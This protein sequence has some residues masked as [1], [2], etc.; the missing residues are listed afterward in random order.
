MR[1]NNISQEKCEE[2]VI[3]LAVK[4]DQ[5]DEEEVL[6]II[7]SIYKR[8]PRD[9]SVNFSGSSALPQ[10]LGNPT[11]M[12]IKNLFTPGDIINLV[13]HRWV[14]ND[15]TKERPY[16]KGFF[17]K[18]EDLI[19]Q[20]EE[21]GGDINNDVFASKKGEPQC[22]MTIAINP[23]KSATRSIENVKAFRHLLIEFD[24]KE[25]SE[26]WDILKNSNLPISTVTYSGG[27]S[28]HACV[29]IDAPNLEEFVFRREIV[30][31]RLE[32]YSPDTATKD[33]TRLTRLAGA[34]RKDVCQDLIAVNI[35]PDSWEEFEA[36]LV[37]KGIIDRPFSWAKAIEFDIE[38]T[39]LVLLGDK[40]VE[41]SGSWLISAQTGVGKSVLAVQAAASFALGLD[42]LGLVPSKP[43]RSLMFQAENGESDVS[44]VMKSIY[45]RLCRG[46]INTLQ[47]LESNCIIRRVGGYYEEQFM[48]VLTKHIERYKPDLIWL[49][50]LTAFIINDITDKATINKFF[51]IDLDPIIHKYR[52]GLV[53]VHHTNKPPRGNELSKWGIDDYIYY[54][55]GA[56][57]MFNYFRAT[58]VL[59]RNGETMEGNIYEWTHGKRRRDAGTNYSKLIQQSSE[60]FDY[61]WSEV[62]LPMVREVR[63]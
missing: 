28:L 57:D 60:K 43:L 3:P 55:S 37:R 7:A 42:F 53:V 6:K 35:G 44:L 38:K 50:P 26:Q 17:I 48:F 39:D 62:S 12:Y 58:S 5:Q 45:K 19:Y 40:F 14:N 29:K 49:D 20:L 13:P 1:D 34:K 31:K 25:L 46:N 63:E 18:Y 30:F 51:R 21:W 9:S 59:K 22:G 56:S 32:K 54:G 41:R 61:W 2:V 16:S 47:Q 10:P 24:D 11:L 36:D 52:C 23:L 27:K 33:P 8:P 4:R 15:F